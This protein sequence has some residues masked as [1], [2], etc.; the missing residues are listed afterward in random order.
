[1][2]NFSKV[3]TYRK[4]AEIWLECKKKHEPVNMRAT[5]CHG[6][7]KFWASHLRDDNITISRFTAWAD[8]HSDFWTYLLR[9]QFPLL[10]DSLYIC[11]FFI[12]SWFLFY[13]IIISASVCINFVIFDTAN[14]NSGEV[15]G[16]QGNHSVIWRT[17]PAP[18]LNT[19]GLS[20][21]VMSFA[22]EIVTT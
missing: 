5:V 21:I 15:N 14:M 4:P 11:S 6:D 20:I 13:F 1:M 17:Y 2:A 9:W 16:A 10:V 22:V 8:L 19:V 12:L 7:I 18:V 3:K